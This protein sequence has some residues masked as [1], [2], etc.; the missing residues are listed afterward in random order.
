[1]IEE[2]YLPEQKE[3][4][5]SNRFVGENGQPIPWKIKALKEKEHQKIKKREG[6]DI[7]KYWG[8]FCANCV[9][10]P[11]LNDEELLKSYGCHSADEVLKEMLTMGEYMILLKTVREQNC[12]EERKQNIKYDIKKP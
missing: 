12:F 1:M 3:I 6:E 7:E 5:I 11:N 10:L 9:V 8:R 2:Q 4:V